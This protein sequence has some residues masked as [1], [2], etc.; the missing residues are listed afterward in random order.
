MKEEILKKRTKLVEELQSMNNQHQQLMNVLKQQETK[1]I[2]TEG[3]I[4]ALDELLK[5]KSEEIN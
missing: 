4:M 3:A 1:M 2:Q 5:E